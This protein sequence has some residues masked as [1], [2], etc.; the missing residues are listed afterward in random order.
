M[1]TNFDKSLSIAGTDVIRYKSQGL[2]AA[3]TLAAYYVNIRKSRD[4]ALAYAYKG[5]AIDSTDA[6]LKSIRDLLEKSNNQKPTGK[7][8]GKPSASIRKPSDHS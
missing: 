2:T 1:V 7:T 8:T 5:L 4:T 6:A 3:K